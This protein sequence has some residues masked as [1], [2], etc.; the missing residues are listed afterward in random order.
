MTIQKLKENFEE[1]LRNTETLLE[2]V[3]ANKENLLFLY[4][5]VER[6]ITAADSEKVEQEL[7]R[8]IAY[9][10]Q[11]FLKS[12]ED[13]QKIFDINPI[14]L[15]KKETGKTKEELEIDNPEALLRIANYLYE[16]SEIFFADIAETAIAKIRAIKRKKLEQE[17]EVELELL[18]DIVNFSE[19]F[20]DALMILSNDLEVI[21]ESVDDSLEFETER[22]DEEEDDDA[23]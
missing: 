15:K 20:S 7:N 19:S 6:S 8:I 14:G 10:Y 13:A 3:E 23:L 9:T 4:M 1:E 12:L 21:V 5:E 11:P 2:F 16:E 17:K 22:N 18:S